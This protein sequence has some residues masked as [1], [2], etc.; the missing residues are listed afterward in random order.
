VT[1]PTSLDDVHSDF[2]D[3]VS[4]AQAV[5]LLDKN[6][7]L[8][9]VREADEWDAGHAPQA[10]HIPMSE[11]NQRADE[12]PTDRTIVCVCHVGGRSAM[13][14]DALNRSGWHALNLVG[15]ME[16]WQ[17]AG[18]DVVTDDGAAGSVI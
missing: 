6:A 18:F 12:L 4:A 3:E 9:D 2:V 10:V 16:A 7:L 15:G 13:V 11:L 8:L 5:E 1:Q 14:S 17:R